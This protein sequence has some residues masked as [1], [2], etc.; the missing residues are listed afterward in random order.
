MNAIYA[1]KKYELAY[2]LLQH[3]IYGN[4]CQLL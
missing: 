1:Q 4:A 2:I 3:D